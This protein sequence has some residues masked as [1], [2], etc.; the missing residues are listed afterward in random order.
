MELESSEIAVKTDEVNELLTSVPRWFIRW[1]VSVIFAIMVVGLVLSLFI[2]YPDKLTAKTIVTTVNP[3][4]T[5]VSKTNGN[6]ASISVKNGDIVRAGQFLLSIE[7]SARYKDLLSIMRQIE[8][9]QS[10]IKSKNLLDFQ[11]LDSIELGE[12]TPLYISFLKSYSDFKIQKEVNPQE[13]EIEIIDKELAQYSQ[14]K[15]K[16]QSQEDTY[17][18]E[19]QLIEKDYARFETLFQSGSISAKDYEDKKRDFLSSKRNFE[20]IKITN[21]NNKLTISSLEKNKLQ[22]KLLAFQ[23]FEKKEQQLLQSI[24]TLKSGVD[25]WESKYVLKSPIEGRVSLY[26]Y[27]DQNQN[28]KDGDEVLS[29]VP[30]Q[31]SEIIARLYLPVQNSGKLKVGQKV[32]I[33]LDNYPYQ[34]YGMLN[35]VVKAISNVPKNDSY[36]VEVSLP[37]KLS[38]SYGKNLEYKEEMTG[39]ADKIG[40]AHV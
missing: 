14:L 16:Y 32:N 39:V 38:S 27:W 34:E 3:P 10:S 20:N 28:L 33:K 17:K 22:L 35:G 6:I 8:G 5:L 24:Q 31:K 18:E 26:K 1:G 29:I 7:N 2:K 30:L 23:E 13:Q 4:V 21:I 12:L 37:N 9:V 40:R 36:S 19:L 15:T 11:S 25:E